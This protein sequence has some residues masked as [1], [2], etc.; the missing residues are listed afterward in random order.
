MLQVMWLAGAALVLLA[1]ATV[2]IPAGK[3]LHFKVSIYFSWL[4]LNQ[5][6][7]VKISSRD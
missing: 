5:E 3:V 6:T 1:A 7:H 4:V 2:G